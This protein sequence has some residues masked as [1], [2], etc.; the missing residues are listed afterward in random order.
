MT[1]LILNSAQRRDLRAQAH[2]LEPVVM[3]G[4][5]GLTPAVT[6]EA[7]AAL[8]AHGLIKV[9][10]AIDDRASREAAYVALCDQ[11]DAAPVQHIGKLFV[12]WR[13]VPEK[14]ASRPDDA[15]PGPRIVKLVTPSKSKTRRP[16]VK[17]I[18]LLGNQRISA[19]GLVK[20]AKPKQSSTKK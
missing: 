18:K 3:I 4:A 17:K 2:H 6:K 14:A 11:L 9:R 13:P 16:Q 7:N 1:A 10:A 5:E 20:R 19:G 12:V 8:N 15:K